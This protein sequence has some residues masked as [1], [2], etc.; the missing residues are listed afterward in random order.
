[1]KQ[2]RGFIKLV[3]IYSILWAAALPWR[4]NIFAVGLIALEV[5]VLA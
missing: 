5:F 2:T 1:M 3:A 4:P